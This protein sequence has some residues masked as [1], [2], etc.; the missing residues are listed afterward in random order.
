MGNPTE[1]RARLDM[2]IEAA[3]DA[4]LAVCSIQTGTDPMAAVDRAVAAIKT[5][6]RRAEA[7]AMRR[8]RS[9]R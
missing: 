6:M 4:F 2:A 3:A 8:E 1:H 5:V 9:P 7:E